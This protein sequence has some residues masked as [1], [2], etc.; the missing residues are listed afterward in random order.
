MMRYGVHGSALPGFST[1][2]VFMANAGIDRTQPDSL[3]AADEDWARMIDTNVMAHVRA[4]RVLVPAWLADG[5]GGRF[6]VTASAA[7]LLTQVSSLIYSVTKHAAVALA[8][9]M[10]IEYGDAGIRI[11]CICP[12]GVRTP[13]LELAM[14][15]PAGAAAL[16]A[17]GVIEPEEVAEAVVQGIA[18]ERVLIL[19]HAEVA[20][21]MALKGSQ[22]DRWIGGM[23]K[24]VRNARGADNAG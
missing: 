21:H 24:L 6:V 18:D 15:E 5:Q 8:E 7:G 22:P 1:S 3:Q 20:Q 11:S 14:D 16:T 19:P 23:R 2:G 4:A 17:G 9:W 10:A 12:Q 13:M